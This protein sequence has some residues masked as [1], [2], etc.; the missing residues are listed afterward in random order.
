MC[1]IAVIQERL[2]RFC[3]TSNIDGCVKFLKSEIKKNRQIE[4]YN[5]IYNNFLE[6]HPESY[7]ENTIIP[8]LENKIE[9]M[10]Y[11]QF[12]NYL[13]FKQCSKC[14]ISDEKIN[15]IISL[16]DTEYSSVRFLFVGHQLCSLYSNRIFDDSN[17]YSKFNYPNFRILGSPF[18]FFSNFKFPLNRKCFVYILLHKSGNLSF[19]SMND[20][21]FGNSNYSKIPISFKFYSSSDG[22]HGGLIPKA[23][24]FFKHDLFHMRYLFDNITFCNFDIIMSMS[25]K[26][27]KGTIKR[28]MIDIFLHVEI[29]EKAIFSRRNFE[30]VNIFDNFKDSFL[31]ILQHID[32]H[33]AGN[34]FKYLMSSEDINNNILM[35][36]YKKYNIE[37]IELC[38]YLKQI[39]IY[40]KEINERRINFNHSKYKM[41][42]TENLL[43]KLHSEF[44]EYFYECNFEYF[45]L[46]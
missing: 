46:D 24:E 7:D 3:G 41:Q 37:Q 34:L 12:Y 25:Q 18:I 4:S 20:F 28:R 6:I 8:G 29:F 21:L 44:L 31:N 10:I 13:L 42:S 38:K 26:F 23:D 40:L 39:R 9:L 33:D 43:K 19:E 14:E 32:P 5:L 30:I 2:F 45:N 15:W 22:P 36:E 1:S 16:F 17:I 35:K 27:K 11:C